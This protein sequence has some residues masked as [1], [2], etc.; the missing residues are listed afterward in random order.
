MSVVEV[1]YHLHGISSGGCPDDSNHISRLDFVQKF[2]S[3]H[4]HRWQDEEGFCNLQYLTKDDQ[5]KT[6]ALVRYYE[7]V[8]QVMPSPQSC[9]LVHL[10]QDR[11][12]SYSFCKNFSWVHDQNGNLH[13][14]VCIFHEGMRN[15]KNCFVFY[16]RKEILV[17]VLCKIVFVF[18]FFCF[19]HQQ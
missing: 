13:F 19:A 7:G 1:S 16:I 6:V 18:F 10:V 14:S 5:T 3:Q 9:I 12:C 17:Y 4:F 11:I 15:H 8:V 2:H